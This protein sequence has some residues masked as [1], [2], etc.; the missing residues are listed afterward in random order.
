MVVRWDGYSFDLVEVR[1]VADTTD[2]GQQAGAT[3]PSCP[4]DVP[5][6]DQ[7]LN[8]QLPELDSFALG[9][10]SYGFD[11]TDGDCSRL[12]FH[13]YLDTPELEQALAPYADRLTIDYALTPMAA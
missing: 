9:I 8:E 3:A 5:A 1:S 12:Q 10:I 2:A 7:L 6:L 13:A 11:L 4:T